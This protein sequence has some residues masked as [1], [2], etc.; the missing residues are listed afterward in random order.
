[1][2]EENNETTA[3]VKTIISSGKTGISMIAVVLAVM[4][5]VV[6]IISSYN[7]LVDSDLQ[8]SRS[9]A[10]I[11]TDLE[12]RADLLPN[13]ASAVKGSAEF[14]HNTLVQV[15]EAR[16]NDASV[17]KNRIHKAN[18]MDEMSRQDAQLGMMIGGVMTLNENYPTLQTTQQF[19]EF[20][21]QVTATENQIL[22][23]RQT[24]NAAVMQ[25]QSVCRTFPTTI[26]AD[27]F[28]FNP[29]KYQMY[30]PPNMTR[31]ATVPE[32]TFDFSNL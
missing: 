14:E 16:A 27:W 4:C 15:I 3:D 5:I 23:D 13:L 22:I 18:T 8:V 17:L 6:P 32:I 11:R 19:R 7:A 29:D 1:M 10:N 21:A 30:N 25:Y 9:A 31:A 2:A 26:M 12:R 20:Q 28:G 24:Y